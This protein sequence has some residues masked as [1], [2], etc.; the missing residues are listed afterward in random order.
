LGRTLVFL[1]IV[2]SVSA[3]ASWSGWALRIGGTT[4]LSFPEWGSKEDSNWVVVAPEDVEALLATYEEE[5]MPEDSTEVDSL[6][7]APLLPE[8][9]AWLTQSRSATALTEDSLKSLRTLNGA[10]AEQRAAGTWKPEGLHPNLNFRG[11]SAAFQALWRF[12]E[13]VAVGGK[14]T[15]VLHFGDSQ[16]EGDRITSELRHAFQRR[17][18]GTGPGLVSAVPQAQMPGFV[19]E[20]EGWN[21]HALFGKRDTSLGHDRYGILATV[22]RWTPSDSAAEWT[23]P[24]ALRTRNMGHAR[25]RIWESLHVLAGPLDRDSVAVQIQCDSTNYAAWLK[26]D[27]TSSAL[28][29]ALPPS[30]REVQVRFEA[31]GPDVNALGFYSD[32]GVVVHNVPMRGSSGTIFKKADRAHWTAQVNKL[33]PGLVLLQYGGN[34]MPYVEDEAEARQYARWL[35]SQIRLFKATLPGVP[36]VLIGPSDMSTK[37]GLHFIT[38]PLLPAVREAMMAMAREEHVL[39]WDLFAVMGGQN[40]MPAWVD[41]DPALAAADHIHFTGRGARRI[42]ALLGEAFDAE[43]RLWTAALTAPPL[44]AGSLTPDSTAAP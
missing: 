13:A 5:P 14:A 21:R 27:S 16:I 24:I 37:K 11:D 39:F 36:I 28:H 31:P 3:L 33:S 40:S 19:H 34:T 42:G 17:W 38:Y 7:V 18:G 4:L 8:L 1:A 20:A 44:E 15:H 9:A 12:F 41:A 6:E 32:T 10:W 26:G 22:G 2:G 35:A 25:N 30:C 29:V 43:Y 23:D